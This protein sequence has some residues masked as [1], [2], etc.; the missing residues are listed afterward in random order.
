MR[1]VVALVVRRVS[2]ASRLSQQHRAGSALALLLALVFGSAQVAAHDFW[3][4]P[5]RFQSPAGST[6][7]L[8]LRVGE[9]LRGE[10]VTRQARRVERFIIRGPDGERPVGGK[11]GQDPAGLA[12]L[13]T[14]GL[15][16]VGYRSLPSSVTLTASKFEQYLAEE[17]LEAIIEQRKKMGRSHTPGV[18]IYS[19]CA[20]AL[21]RADAPIGQASAPDASMTGYDRPLDFRLELIPET[22]PYDTSIATQRVRLLYDGRPLQDTL[23]VAV[24]QHARVPKQSA[25][26]DADGRVVL[27]LTPGVWLVKAVH[28]V[29]APPGVV[30]EW[31]SLWAS[32]TFERPAAPIA[33]R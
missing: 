23:V 28:M 16:I 31:E 19:R 33:R 6:L 15:Y 13:P 9:D 24:P 2:R 14:P 18:E 20:K 3:I 30:A 32:L 21:V 8:A 25:R 29:Q 7:A 22:N 1:A 4:M 27:T 12:S 26:T 11:E 10:P 5:A 17:G